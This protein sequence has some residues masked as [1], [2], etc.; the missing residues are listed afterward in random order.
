MQTTLSF[1][2]DDTAARFDELSSAG[3]QSIIDD[4]ANNGSESAMA[5]VPQAFRRKGLCPIGLIE[6][7]H[8][9]PIM[10]EYAIAVGDCCH[11]YFNSLPK[12][13]RNAYID[14]FIR[15]E[16]LGRHGSLEA[17]LASAAFRRLAAGASDAIGQVLPRAL[18][19]LAASDE[20]MARRIISTRLNREGR[21]W[22][23]F[24]RDELCRRGNVRYQ[25]KTAVEIEEALSA[26][27]GA[28]KQVA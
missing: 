20:G 1:T 6:V 13:K 21:L 19:R 22:C 3:T 28:A 14:G 15:F 9:Q 26:H 4:I 10:A 24:W 7:D 18:A 12:A 5:W 25:L 11:D 8:A 2:V 17:F 27:F 16:I 23:A